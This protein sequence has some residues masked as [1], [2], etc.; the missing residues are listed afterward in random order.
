MILDI[1][2]PGRNDPCP[3][4]SGKKYKKCCG[5]E[6]VLPRKELTSQGM[7]LCM[8][9]LVNLAGGKVVI[10]DEELDKLTQDNEMG[11]AVGYN[12]DD[13]AFTFQIVKI[14][15]SPIAQPS[16]RLIT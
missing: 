15:R 13:D 1:K 7:K 9:H 2:K 6:D 16:K 10:P 4:D 11:M 8:M 14:K 12:A 3:C 5:K